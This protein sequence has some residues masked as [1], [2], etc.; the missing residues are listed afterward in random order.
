VK[1]FEDRASGAQADRAGLR[2]RTCVCA[3]IHMSDIPG[4]PYGA[5]WEERRLVLVANLTRWDG[6]DFR[7]LA[8]MIS[9]V[10]KVTYP[11]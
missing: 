5:L 2:R 6:V 7:R 4:F 11:L 1:I 9:I 3:D 8:P 10:T